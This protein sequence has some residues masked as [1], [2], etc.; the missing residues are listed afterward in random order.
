MFGNSWHKKEKPL[1]GLTGAGGGVGSN[2]VA[3]G[4]AGPTNSA[5]GGYISEYESGG[6]KY[7]SHTFMKTGTWVVTSNDG[8]DVEYLV[9]AGGGGGGQQHGGGAGAGGFRTNL[10]GHPLA[11]PTGAY[12]VTPTGGNPSNNGT[13]TVE[14]GQGGRGNSS[15]GYPHSVMNRTAGGN[16]KFDTITATGGGFAGN[17]QSTNAHNEA[18]NAGGTGGSGGADGSCEGN[19]VSPAIAGNT[20][21]S[22]PPQGNPAGT[23]RYSGAGGGGATQAGGN[24]TDVP[25][26]YGAGVA[27]KGG[28]GSAIAIQGSTAVTYA[29][30]GGGGMYQNSPGYPGVPSKRSPGGAGGGGQGGWGGGANLTEFG[31]AGQDGLGGGGGGGGN[32][33]YGSPTGNCNYPLHQGGAGGD[34]TVII[35]YEIGSV[36][37]SAKATGGAISFWSNPGSPT[38]KTCIHKFFTPGTL[39]VSTN[40]T[41]A[42]TVVIGGGGGGGTDCGGGG[43]AGAYRHASSVSLPTASYPVTVGS[44]GQVV[45][46]N[47]PGPGTGG[48]RGW[49]G[50]DSIFNSVTSNGGGGGGGGA[51]TE[52][53]AGGPSGPYASPGNASGGGG[54]GATTG[55]GPAGAYGYAGGNGNNGAPYYAGGGGGAGGVGTNAGAGGGATTYSNGGAGVQLPAMFRDPAQQGDGGSYGANGIGAPGPGSSFHWVCGGGGGSSGDVSQAGAGGNAPHPDAKNYAGGGHGAGPTNNPY[56]NGDASPG[57]NGT[58]GGGGGGDGSGATDAGKGGSGVVLIAYPV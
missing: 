3:G 24:A 56:P 27:G 47:L 49:Y 2:L 30:G 14:V 7:R 31:I 28:D 44:G 55:P 50:G 33:C 53:K 23:S 54:Q 4:E 21:P 34:G 57:I 1:L 18:F 13:Y 20:P 51:P 5:T 11:T 15:G 42:E 46:G 36:G 26:P 6:T 8:F 19:A 32:S 16:S 35:R 40:I 22:S 10:S 45:E 25:S 37:G 17:W 12:P 39:T 52:S 43:G 41:G 48:G 29:G 38:G 9:V 58:G